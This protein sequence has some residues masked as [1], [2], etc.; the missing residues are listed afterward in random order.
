MSSLSLFFPKCV[1]H[2]LHQSWV[3]PFNHSPFL[4]SPAAYPWLWFLVSNLHHRVQSDLEA[5]TQGLTPGDL[6]AVMDADGRS[7]VVTAD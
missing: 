6:L 7:S 3:S 2:A 4:P 1:T 5:G